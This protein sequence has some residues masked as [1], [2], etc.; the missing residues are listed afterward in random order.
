MP[1]RLFINVHNAVVD[2]RNIFHQIRYLLLITQSPSCKPIY[3]TID[4]AIGQVL[5]VFVCLFVVEPNPPPKRNGL[6]A[7]SAV[8]VCMWSL[9]LCSK[10]DKST[11]K[12]HFGERG[13]S[14]PKCSKLAPSKDPLEWGISKSRLLMVTSRSLHCKFNCETGG[15]AVPRNCLKELFFGPLHHSWLRSTHSGG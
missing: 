5:F 13:H 11:S 2:E 7:I 9:M 3:S 8:R 1:K 6:W 4:L 10:Q 12:G 14:K 15:S